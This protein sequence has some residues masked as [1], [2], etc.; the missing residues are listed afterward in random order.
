MVVLEFLVMSCVG[1]AILAVAL[2]KYD[3]WRADVRARE[4]AEVNKD[5]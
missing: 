3:N 5:K 1:G 4:L 2:R